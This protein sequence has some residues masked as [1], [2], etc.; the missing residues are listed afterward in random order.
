MQVVGDGESRLTG[1]NS[2]A[3]R[4][5]TQ[6]VSAKTALHAAGASSAE[7]AAALAWGKGSSRIRTGGCFL[8]ALRL[9]D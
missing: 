7:R 9:G 5:E 2:D 1:M 6:S 8:S 4:V 3:I